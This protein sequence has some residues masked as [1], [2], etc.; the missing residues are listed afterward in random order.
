MHCCEGYHFGLTTKKENT[1]RIKSFLKDTTHNVKFKTVQEPV[2]KISLIALFVILF[3]TQ[4][5][6][7]LGVIP[8]MWT[9]AA[10]PN[11]TNEL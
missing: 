6:K 11:T 7:K 4:N 5:M 9:S 8:H 3:T 1:A 2:C 10:E